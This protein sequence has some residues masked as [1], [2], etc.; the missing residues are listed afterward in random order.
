MFIWI[1]AVVMVVA[2]VVYSW[3]EM[4]QR[5]R[6][7]QRWMLWLWPAAALIAWQAALQW[8]HWHQALALLP[9]LL[10]LVLG[11]LQLRRACP[12]PK[13]PVPPRKSP[14]KRQRQRRSH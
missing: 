10:L 3:A 1:L 11:Y 5:L 4:G 8:L 9:L 2:F 7:R 14:A 6:G 12:A 13:R